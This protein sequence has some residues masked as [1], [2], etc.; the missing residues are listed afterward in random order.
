MAGN[1]H[2]DHHGLA[3][4]EGDPLTGPRLI[5]LAVVWGAGLAV[6][7]QRL[8]PPDYQWVNATLSTL[9]RQGYALAWVMRL[10][11]T[12]FGVLLA[13]GLLLVVR[14]GPARASRLSAA[15]MLVFAVA[16]IVCG[17]FPIAPA[18]EEAA[19]LAATHSRRHSVAAAGMVLALLLG[20]AL[21]SYLE[22][23]SRRR[24]AHLLALLVAGIA[25]TAL[26]LATVKV[27][28]VGQGLMQ[29]ILMVV[30]SAWVLFA[31]DGAGA[32]SAEPGWTSDCR[33]GGDGQE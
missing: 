19:R 30:G 5:R 14:E 31:Y 3:A 21:T 6:V 27:I 28:P 15:W 2:F 7:A 17:V 26:V 11:M 32:G 9:A 29:R 12:G 25:A 13:C 24:A 4:E 18:N 8:G 20:I 33:N 23:S 16:V 10:A 1:L 22:T